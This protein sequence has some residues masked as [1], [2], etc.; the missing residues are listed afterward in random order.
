MDPTFGETEH[1]QRRQADLEVA[2]AANEKR[3]NVAPP[4]VGHAHNCQRQELDSERSSLLMER[5]QVERRLTELVNQRQRFMRLWM[6]RK[7][8]DQ[9]MKRDRALFESLVAERRTAITNFADRL[10]AE[11]DY[12]QARIWRA[13]WLVAPGQIAREYPHLGRAAWVLP[14]NAA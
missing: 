10:E 4:H 12:R 6:P 7:D 5:G 3:L 2:L 14:A 9:D 13:Q 1:L 11:G 8:V